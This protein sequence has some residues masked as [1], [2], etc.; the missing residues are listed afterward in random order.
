MLKR[1]MQCHEVAVVETLKLSGKFKN[2]NLGN[3]PS[4]KSL[5]FAPGFQSSGDIIWFTLKALETLTLD[6]EFETN[7]KS[8]QNTLRDW[9]VKKILSQKNKKAQTI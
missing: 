5:E 1:P 4:L 2:L 3:F 8:L 7:T 9:L 6:G